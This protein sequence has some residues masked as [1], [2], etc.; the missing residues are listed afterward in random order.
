MNRYIFVTHKILEGSVQIPV[1]AGTP[2][3][4][5]RI[6]NAALAGNKFVLL[7]ET[8]LSGDLP[9]ASWRLRLDG[10]LDETMFVGEDVPPLADDLWRAHRTLEA[11]GYGYTWSGTGDFKETLARDDAPLFIKP[12]WTEDGAGVDAFLQ[13][14]ARYEDDSVGYGF[15]IEATLY[16]TGRGDLARGE[17]PFRV[18]FE[19]KQYFIGAEELQLAVGI[20]ETKFLELI[21]FLRKNNLPPQS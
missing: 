8:D 1:D 15:R 13:V 10:G 2:G 6:I 11:A 17:A 9:P 3:E 19:D 5:L 7:G 14:R 12:V 4:A 20:Y 18:K 16:P 21:A